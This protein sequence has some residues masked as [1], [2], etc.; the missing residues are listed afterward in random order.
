MILYFSDENCYLIHKLGT[1]VSKE[2]SKVK[3]REMSANFRKK[4]E[5]HR[6]PSSERVMKSFGALNPSEIEFL[7]D[8]KQF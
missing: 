6:S 4:N 3:K 2:A 8:W 5:N 1:K 7:I